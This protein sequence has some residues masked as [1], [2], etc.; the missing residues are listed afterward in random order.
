MEYAQSRLLLLL[1]APRRRQASRSLENSHNWGAQ[2]SMSTS[3]VCFK[4]SK[5]WTVKGQIPFFFSLER[6]GRAQVSPTINH[7][8]THLH[9][10]THRERHRHG[11][12][13][14]QNTENH[15]CTG[16]PPV[17]GHTT[18]GSLSRSVIVSF[19]LF[20]VFLLDV[21]KKENLSAERWKRSACPNVQWLLQRT[22]DVEML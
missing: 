5:K 3:F 18:L 8:D 7:L 6:N 14:T 2:S 20:F 19:C 16:A 12:K 11:G 21:K 13:K 1:L 22:G 9:T 17:T 4:V 15:T 10:H